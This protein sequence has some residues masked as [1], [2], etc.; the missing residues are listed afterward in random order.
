M[1]ISKDSPRVSAKSLAS[2]VTQPL[3]IATRGSELALAQAHLVGCALGIPYELAIVETSGDKDLHSSLA[4]I[5]GQGVFVKEVQLAVLKGRADIAVHSAKDLPSKTPPGLELV[6]TLAREDPRDAL[7]GSTL[8]ELKEGATVATS[9]PR[10]GAQ[11][12]ALRPDV[13]IVPV[14]GNIATRLTRSE[15]YDSVFVAAAALLRLGLTPAHYELLSPDLICPQVGQG[16]IA[17]ECLS[18]DTNTRTLC[19]SKGDAA[20]MVALRTERA[21]LARFGTGCTLPIGALAWVEEPNH[22]SIEGIAASPDGATV[23]RGKQVGTDPEEVGEGLANLLV[24][25]GALSLIDKPA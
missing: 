10:R 4:K 3:R 13:H 14:R 23:I 6:S 9:S 25:R 17:I 16:I 7:V 19:Q 18:T 1:K 5:G 2:S 20:S 12:L 11:L 22:I 8:A 24:D 21:F 15:D